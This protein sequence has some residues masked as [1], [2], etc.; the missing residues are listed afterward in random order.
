MGGGS[1]L[2]S[3]FFTIRTPPSW[4]ITHLFFPVLN[5]LTSGF[6]YATLS[7]NWLTRYLQ[8]GAYLRRGAILRT[9]MYSILCSV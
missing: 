6:V 1:S 3:Q 5:W 8:G 9:Y 2:R 4:Q 7:L